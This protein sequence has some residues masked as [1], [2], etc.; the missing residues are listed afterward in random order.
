[1]GTSKRFWAL[2][3]AS[4]AA[5]AAAAPG[6]HDNDNTEICVGPDCPQYDGVGGERNFFRSADPEPNDNAGSAG[7]SGEAGMTGSAGS[8]GEPPDVES[9]DATT[10]TPDSSTPLPPACQIAFT[11]PV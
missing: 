6:C 9:P 10:P 11:S 2:C 5:L 3:A 8:G 7:A 1:M 4:A